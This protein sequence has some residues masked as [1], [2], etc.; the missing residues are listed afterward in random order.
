MAFSRLENGS[1]NLWL[2]DQETGKIQRVANEPCNQI[3]PSWEPDS[4]TL[5]YATDCGRSL[6]LTAIARRRVIP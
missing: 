4:K 6:W 1:W 3:E 5:V 2:R